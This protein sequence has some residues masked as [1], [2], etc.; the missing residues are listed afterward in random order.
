MLEARCVARSSKMGRC[1]WAKNQLHTPQEQIAAKHGTRMECV[2][3]KPVI[4]LQG[5]CLANL[6]VT[7]QEYALAAN[8]GHN[9]R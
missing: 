3:V 4:N 2:C 1:S 8:R 7:Q 9:G 5:P 6:Q